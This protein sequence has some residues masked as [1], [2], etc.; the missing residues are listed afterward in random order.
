MKL[1]NVN[2]KV[3]SA[4]AT[5]L[6]ACFFM[7]IDHIGAYLFPGVGWFRV[8]GRLAFPLFAFFISQGCKYSKNKIKRL[9]F[10]AAFAI[11]C[12]LIFNVCIGMVSGNILLT[13]TLSILLIYAYQFMIQNLKDN[14]VSVLKKILYPL[15]FLLVLVLLFFFVECIELE[16]GFFGVIT[17][18]LVTVFDLD[19]YNIAS[20]YSNLFRILGLF[21]GVSLVVLASPI[22]QFFSYLSILV[23]LFYNN[24][25]GSYKM[26]YLFYVFYPFHLL[27]IYFLTLI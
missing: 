23:L 6:V 21:I 19:I 14:S 27:V 11:G 9:I 5:K 4:N 15:S 8:L 25:R 3:L 20:P 12:E 17:P 2:V 10:M 22:I 1:E 26:K 16:Y 18:L 7:L 13:F 24:K